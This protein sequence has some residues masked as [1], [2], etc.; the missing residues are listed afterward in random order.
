MAGLNRV[1]TPLD[2]LETITGI[3]RDSLGAKPNQPATLPIDL[4]DNQFGRYLMGRILDVKSNGPQ[5]L[6]QFT[7]MQGQQIRTYVD[8]ARQGL[9]A[10]DS[11]TVQSALNALLDYYLWQA[12]AFANKPE[13][14]FEAAHR[15]VRQRKVTIALNFLRYYLGG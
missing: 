15:K 7:Q 11:P 1:Y 5:M 2:E 10:I 3:S 12:D 14:I 4:P 13:L 9:S 8:A 6:Q